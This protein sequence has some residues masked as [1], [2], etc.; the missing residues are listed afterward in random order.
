VT[1]AFALMLA[2]ALALATPANLDPALS[3][4]QDE[5]ATSNVTSAVTADAKIKLDLAR[6]QRQAH[7]FEQASQ[8]LI[9][10]LKSDIPYDLKRTALLELALTAEDSGQ[11]ARAIQIFAQYLQR[12]PEDPG[13]PEVMLRQA[14]LYRQMGAY[15]MA[16]S[17][18]YA[19]MTTILNLKLDNNGYYQHLVLQ[20]QTEIAET[21]YLQG[22]FNEAA[23]F[24]NRLL[25]LDSAELNKAEI[26]LKLVRSLSSSG[27]YE[28]TVREAQNLL[29]TNPND[30]EARFLLAVSL[31]HL[32]HKQEAMR[33]ALF[34]LETPEGK[35]WRQS[36]G[37]QIANTFY[38]EGDYTDALVVYH[39]LNHDDPAPE[40]RIPILYQI[41]LIHER[42]Q[43]TDEAITAYGQVEELGPSLT[44][45]I[46]PALQVVLDMSQW[47]KKYLA[48]QSQA[49]QVRPAVSSLPEPAPTH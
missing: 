32:G 1:L 25:K 11:P 18:F 24:F 3:R 2:P 22:S 5:I 15:S 47:R 6:H 36:I 49:P 48:W 43:Q 26:R 13:V 8:T 12:F 9:V 46:E 31:Q 21:Y 29:A 27:R 45:P 17:K 19:V 7:D 35:A 37:N 41:G 4:T 16:L 38:A 42:L 28:E 39:H 44:K 23:N 33:Q 14:L 10:M 34:L 40:W 20:A 30:T